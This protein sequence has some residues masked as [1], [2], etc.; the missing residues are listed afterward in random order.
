MRKREK[1]SDQGRTLKRIKGKGNV[2]KVRQRVK[3]N[4]ENVKEKGRD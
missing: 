1:I 2:F 4:G 3:I